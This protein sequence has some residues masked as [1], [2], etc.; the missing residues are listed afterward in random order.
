MSTSNLTL[1]QLERVW[2]APK[3]DK[4]PS[5]EWLPSQLK[6]ARLPIDLLVVGKLTSWT[7]VKCDV[8]SLSQVSPW[9]RLTSNALR[10]F[11]C[12]PILMTQEPVVKRTR[13]SKISAR[14]TLSKFDCIWCCKYPQAA[15][16][17]QVGKSLKSNDENA[18]SRPHA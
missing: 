16:E 13:C 10:L 7:H 9:G 17:A 4:D 15:E 5:N 2:T 1:V 12:R 11:C 18:L 8:D 14:L 6:I 3:C